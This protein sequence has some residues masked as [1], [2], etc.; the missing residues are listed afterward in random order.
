MIR[1]MLVLMFAMA[2]SGCGTAAS[3]RPLTQADMARFAA[4]ADR[5]K[6]F[7][8]LYESGSLLTRDVGTFATMAVGIDGMPV[9]DVTTS[10]YLDVARVPGRHLVDLDKDGLL[11]ALHPPPIT[12]TMLAGRASFYVMQIF[13]GGKKAQISK[14]GP[15][16]GMREVLARTPS[17]A[18]VQ[19]AGGALPPSTLHLTVDSAAAPAAA[20]FAAPAAAPAAVPVAAPADPLASLHFDHGRPRPD[21]V[22]VIIGNSAY[23]G[24][25]I[26]AVPPARNDAAMMRRYAVE[27]LG[28][29]EDNV[30]SLDDATAAQMVEVF[31]NDRDPKGKLYNWV[32]PGVS[33]V[34][35]YYA[36][37][38]APSGPGGAAMLVPADASAASIALSGYPLA[39]LYANLAKLPATGVTVVL[40][41]CFSGGSEA[42]SLVPSASPVSIAVK[43][44]AVPGNLTVI[45]AG[46]AGQIASWE[47]DGSHGLFTE[48]FLKGMA[49]AADQ[50]PTGNG[51]GS[52]GLDELGRYLDQN[53]SYRARR[54]YGR[55]QTVQVVRG[56]GS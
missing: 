40:E 50:P 17:V 14:V 12:D 3:T 38:G 2:L 34:F 32:K 45:T 31:G 55:D 19:F 18:P 25:D 15:E 36:G 51:D 1:T 11:I 10:L 7:F 37:H 29:A 56:Q 30:I 33:R 20:P 9:G 21:D 48:Y 52:V 28:V 53:V 4:P 23:T 54:Y 27:A 24:R 8:F 49:G 43:P 16:F 13:S 35:V 44:Q 41:A 6:A 26:P 22:A 42:G 5:A 46:T 47:K 39:T